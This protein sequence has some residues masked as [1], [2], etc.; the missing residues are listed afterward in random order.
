MHVNEFSLTIAFT[1]CD[2]LH[3]TS[4]DK[5]TNYFFNMTVCL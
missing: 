5:G 4:C 2:T 3:H 1:M